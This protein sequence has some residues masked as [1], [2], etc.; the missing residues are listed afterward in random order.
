[1]KESI[2]IEYNFKF[3]AIIVRPEK[4]PTT[5]MV[6]ATPATTGVTEDGKPKGRSL[7]GR[8]PSQITINA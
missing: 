5:N 2:L 3:R 4:I 1:M 8:K 6:E 7:L